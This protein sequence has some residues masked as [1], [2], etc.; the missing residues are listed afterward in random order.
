MQDKIIQSLANKS[1]SA[2]F[3]WMLDGFFENM[4]ISTQQ[5]A[6]MLLTF[7]IIS[8]SWNIRDD[9]KRCSVFFPQTH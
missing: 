5:K 3:L 1:K 8:H 6:R 9:L 4:Q 7:I 2:L